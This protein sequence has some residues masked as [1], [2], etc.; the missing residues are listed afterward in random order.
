MEQAA[1]ILFW[2][3]FL[4]VLGASV[5]FAYEL[6]LKRNIRVQPQWI[7]IVGF[8]A[9]MASIGFNSVVNQGTSFSGANILVLASWG[10]LIIYFIFEYLTRLKNFGVLMV[11]IATF[12][13]GWAQLV[14]A[15]SSI[16]PN[17]ELLSEQMDATGIVIHVTLIV[18]ANVLFLVGSAASGL[19][20]YQSRM[21]KKNA[22]NLLSRRLPSLSNLETLA[23]RAIIVALP[24]YFSA[25]MFG[26]LRAIAVDVDAWWLDVRVIVSGLVLFIFIAYLLLYSRNKSS[27]QVTAK[28]A[29]AGGVVVLVLM[30]LARVYPYGFH[31]FGAM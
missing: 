2:L 14:G 1:T 11:P 19:Y 27:G 13:L 28:I 16:A 3:A 9:L 10:L 7:T 15:R 25:Q 30:V 12:L 23:S 8:V 4:S 21:L 26:T 18:F 20:L 17:I 22:S 6:L 29:L 24:I 5:V 31:L